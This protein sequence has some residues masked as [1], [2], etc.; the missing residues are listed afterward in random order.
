[1]EVSDLC[2]SRQ[3]LFQ[4]E[5]SLSAAPSSYLVDSI[6]N[7]LFTTPSFDHLSLSLPHC[8]IFSH[9]LFLLPFTFFLVKF[10]RVETERGGRIHPRLIIS[11]ILAM[12]ARTS[13]PQH[14]PARSSRL[15]T[16]TAGGNVNTLMVLLL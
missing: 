12:L 16:K 14:P 7:S 2:V 3:V 9:V 1:M 8:L 13:G 6:C 4:Y 11:A 15:I 10:H 5:C